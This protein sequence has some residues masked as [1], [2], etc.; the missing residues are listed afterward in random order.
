MRT[1]AP[2]PK[3]RSSWRLGL[4]LGLVAGC[5]ATLPEPTVEDAQRA[6]ERWHDASQ[7]QLEAGRS[8]LL[9]RC[10]SCHALPL[11]SDETPERWPA[12]VK[13]MAKPAGLSE[14]QAESLVRYLVITSARR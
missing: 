4:A 6:R 8:V 13:E 11:P 10:S 1:L 3:L 2:C 5:A 12:V 9:S 7:A 14:E